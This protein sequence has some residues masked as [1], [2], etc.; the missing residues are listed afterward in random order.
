MKNSV[1]KST[2]IVS[3]VNTK[4]LSQINALGITDA[5]KEKG[6]SKSIF[7]KDFNNKTDRTSCRTKFL[8]AISLYLLNVAHNKKDLADKNLSLAKD[9]AKKYYLAEDKFA[10]VADYA[11]SNMDAQ[12]RSAV[13]MFIDIQKENVAPKKEIK[14]RAKKVK[15][16]EPIVIPEA[17]LI[18]E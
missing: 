18:Q 10:D 6:T 13:A 3:T 2:T 17:I 11:S 9:I 15:T 14:V 4:M 1:K 8:S 7:K 16:N 12:K 5:L